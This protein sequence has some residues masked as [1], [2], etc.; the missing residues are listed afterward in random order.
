[1][2]QSNKG[3]HG[4]EGEDDE[5][6]NSGHKSSTVVH[7]SEKLKLPEIPLCGCMSVQFYQPYF[8]V[9]TSDI[10][11]RISYAMFY[12]KRD[13]FLSYIKDRPDA[14]GPLWIATTL[15]FTV[16]VT[17]HVNSWIKSYML[18]THWYSYTSKNVII[19]FHIVSNFYN[20]DDEHEGFYENEDDNINI[21]K[22]S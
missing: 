12:C 5:E 9:E 18:G 17:S 13:A 19:S 14:Y 8:D 21:N 10:I 1:M 4:E 15:I 3:H 22:Y 7:Q 20:A 6:M 16:A 11:S 2:T